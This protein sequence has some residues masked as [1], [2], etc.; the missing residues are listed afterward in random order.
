MTGWISRAYP[1][2]FKIRQKTNMASG[3]NLYKLMY[4][5]KGQVN[6][7]SAK[8]ASIPNR[9]L[10]GVLC[11]SSLGDNFYIQC[12]YNQ[13]KISKRYKVS[14]FTCIIILGFPRDFVSVDSFVSQ[15][16]V[17]QLVE[18]KLITRGKRL[19]ISIPEDAG[20]CFNLQNANENEIKQFISRLDK[21]KE[22][23][24][25]VCLYYKHMWIDSSR[26]PLKDLHPLSCRV[27]F[28]PPGTNIT[29]G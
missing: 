20:T 27:S 17:G 26:L 18:T 10:P 16:D 29:P 24:K 11:L 3:G 9:T 19:A 2:E 4:E 15:L 7:R 6:W 5:V 21:I 23:G 13:G 28:L 14:S 25:Q 8:T 22:Q 1:R 12:K